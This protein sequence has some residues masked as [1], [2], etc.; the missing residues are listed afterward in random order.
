MAK[1]EPSFP[2]IDLK[3][4]SLDS[5]AIAAICNLIIKMIEIT[6]QDQHERNIARA[7]R[8][9]TLIE[10]KVLKLPPLETKDG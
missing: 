4:F 6:P 5:A 1:N 9:I 7:E 2:S 8:F 10:E 3:L